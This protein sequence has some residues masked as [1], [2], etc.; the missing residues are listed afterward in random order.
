LPVAAL[1]LVAIAAGCGSDGGSSDDENTSPG[2]TG[3]AANLDGGET[4]GAANVDG[5]NPGSGGSDTGSGGTEPQPT[6]G[7][8]AASWPDNGR[9]TIDVDGTER[10]YVFTAPDGY[11]GT[12]PMK[13]IFVW[14]GLGGTIDNMDNQFFSYYGMGNV[15]D[16]ST[17]LAAGQ[18]LG[19]ADDPTGY[20]WRNTNGEDVAFV[21]ALIDWFNSNFCID[22]A[23]IFSTGMSYG[24]VMSNTVGCELGDLV[25]AI[26]PIA[27]AGPGFGGFGDPSCVGQVAAILVHGTADDVVTIDIGEGSRDHWL[28]ANS[29]GTDT[30]PVA[31]TEYCVAYGGCDADYPVHWCVHDGGHTIPDFSAQ[32]I[33]DFFERF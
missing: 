4:G 10:E 15:A 7:C 9:A 1:S 26:G 22:A 14:H 16:G 8:D 27:G 25:R 6:S 3:G 24:G 23:R 18:G 5:G 11:D 17:I 32:A 28:G 29:C 13:L 21:R 2:E 33:W 20:A 19:T 12:T 30:S 31:P